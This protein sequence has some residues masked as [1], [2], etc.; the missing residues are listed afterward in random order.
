MKLTKHDYDA[1]SFFT[2]NGQEVINTDFKKGLLKIPKYTNDENISIYLLKNLSSE[3]QLHLNEM[4]DVD[5]D[6]ITYTNF[7]SSNNYYQPLSGNDTYI[8]V[9]EFNNMCDFEYYRKAENIITLEPDFQKADYDYDHIDSIINGINEGVNIRDFLKFQYNEKLHDQSTN[10]A[11]EGFNDKFYVISKMIIDDKP[12]FLLENERY[13]DEAPDVICDENKNVFIE[14]AYNG[15]LDLFENYEDTPLAAAFND[16]QIS[17]LIECCNLGFDIELLA[18]SQYSSLQMTAIKD[19]FK[20]GLNVS[21]YAQLKSN[22]N[23]NKPTLKELCELH[24]PTTS[25]KTKP[26]IKVITNPISY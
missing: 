11:L 19:D 3:E 2:S 9:K 20:R 17:I 6:L 4:N 8:I 12:Y 10:I 13:G 21:E 1:V 24:Q 15:Y 25:E 23:Q 26:N 16:E 22:L 7:M 5:I 14:N 18:K